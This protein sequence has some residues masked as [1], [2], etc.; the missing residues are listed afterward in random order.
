VPSHS[1]APGDKVRVPPDV[2][3]LA[4]F[5]CWAASDS[6]PERGKISFLGGEVD[7]DMSPE[8]INTHNTVRGCLTIALGLLADEEDSGQVFPDG[9]L[10]I[11]VDAD[12]ANEPDLVFVRFDSLELGRVTIGEPGEDPNRAIELIGSPDLVVEVVSPSSVRKD[13]R[14]LRERYLRAGV[15]E[16]WLIDARREPLSFEILIPADHGF[17]PAP[18]DAEGYVCSSLWNRR[19]R[20]IRQ[21][22]HTGL[23]RYRLESA[24][25]SG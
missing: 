18:T 9:A 3:D 4:S 15:R 17:E 11:N 7:V 25:V 23:V 19:F 16:Y 13:K 2:V 21:Q 6:F 24:A 5:R 22:H 10:V 20:L 1:S 14:D 12:L 8:N